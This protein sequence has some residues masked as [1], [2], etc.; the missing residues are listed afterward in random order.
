MNLKPQITSGV[1]NSNL[2]D[3]DACRWREEQRTK[4][5]RKMNGFSRGCWDERADVI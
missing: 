4:E 2:A 5:E 1:P 3:D